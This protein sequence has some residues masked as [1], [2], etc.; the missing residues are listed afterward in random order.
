MVLRFKTSL[1]TKITKHALS[2]IVLG[3]SILTEC[4]LD[5]WFLYFYDITFMKILHS[6]QLYW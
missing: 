2:S 1:I 5:L 3:S 6:R 4:E